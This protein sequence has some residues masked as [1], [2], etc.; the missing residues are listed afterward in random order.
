[1]AA[2]QSGTVVGMVEVILVSQL[3]LGGEDRGLCGT[4]P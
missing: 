3:V 1:M 4:V 2:R